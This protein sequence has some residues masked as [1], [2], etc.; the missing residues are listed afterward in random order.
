MFEKILNDYLK[1]ECGAMEQEI[2]SSLSEDEIKNIYEYGCCWAGAGNF[3][4]YYQ[5]N[6]FFNK[7]PEECLEVLQLAIN[8][9][10]IDPKNFNFRR[11]DIVWL[12][13]EVTVQNFMSYLEDNEYL[14]DEDEEE[15]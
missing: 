7:Y 8:D 14:Y 3:L 6:A 5:T 2:L 11:N 13:V 9:C 12:A 4:Y 10:W 15:E 1:E